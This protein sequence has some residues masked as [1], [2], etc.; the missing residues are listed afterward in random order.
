MRRG[1][2]VE[3]NPIVSTKLYKQVIE[4]IKERIYNKT[5]KKGDKLPSERDM[6]VMLGVSR[7]AIREGLRS[8]EMLGITESRQGE[9]TF[10]VSSFPE[11]K[12]FEPLS[13]IFMLENNTVELLDVRSMLEIEC[14]GMA[15][16]FIT[17]EELETLDG[18]RLLLTGER[19]GKIT[20]EAD[21][22][23][24]SLIAKASHHTLLYYMYSS[25]NEVVSHHI[26]DMRQLILED[27][28]NSEILA[29]QH[30]EIYQAILLKNRDQA[31][32]AMREH[33][34]YVHDQLC[35]KYKE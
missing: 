21:Y 35:R 20:E 32:Q 1:E 2:I 31:R 17:P 16:E 26:V 12:I 10:I 15:A 7:T 33:M 27:P 22:T 19:E 13:L 6:A 25:I 18:Y 34:Q 5:L 14:A 29:L 8:L 24:H 3:F 11:Y 28:N 9:G 30:N 23:Y 4:Q